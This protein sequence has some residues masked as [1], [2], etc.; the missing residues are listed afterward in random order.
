MH[1]DSHQSGGNAPPEPSADA[2]LYDQYAQIVFAY[3][4]IHALTREDAEDVTCEVFLAALE[5]DNLA[6][7][8]VS[9]RL[10][11]LRRVASNKIVDLY[12]KQMR[13]P[14]IVLSGALESLL[15]DQGTRA[16][17]MLA[18]QRE[19]YTQLYAMIKL[20]PPA[21]QQILRLRYGDG[22]RFSEISTLLEKRETAIRKLCSRALA[23][24][25]TIYSQHPVG[26]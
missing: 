26:G 14:H 24:L 11:W 4:K 3:A 12:R 20:L 21:Q 6:A 17:E 23:A 13:H 10:A 19:T 8:P 16:P 9:T 1:Q 2:S 18:L 15:E 25:R 5:Q 22:L 7:L